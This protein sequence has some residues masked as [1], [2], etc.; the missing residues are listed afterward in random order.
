M[1]QVK[2]VFLSLLG[3]GFALVGNNTP[4]LACSSLTDLS[5]LTQVPT[6]VPLYRRDL[7]SWS[8]SIKLPN[9][10]LTPP[11]EKKNKQFVSHVAKM[12]K[13]SKLL[14]TFQ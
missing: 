14:S 13:K 6:L 5:L 4:R 7:A 8:C 2:S 10:H 11:F 9:N 3:E 12:K 1:S